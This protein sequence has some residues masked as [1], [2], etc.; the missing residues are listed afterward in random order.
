M[1][2]PTWPC[3]GTGKWEMWLD[4]L[5]WTHLQSDVGENYQVWSLESGLSRDLTSVC[6]KFL[7]L[8]L[9]VMRD[10]GCFFSFGL[11]SLNL[12]SQSLAML[13]SLAAEGW[14]C[15]IKVQESFPG[16]PASEFRPEWKVFSLVIHCLSSLSRSSCFAD[17]GIS[18]IVI[19]TS[20]NVWFVLLKCW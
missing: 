6:D 19:V 2:I 14:C 17:L 7:F 13:V 11:F 10:I 4:S 8:A 20:F 1:K 12:S 3:I 9:A 18:N 5:F 15:R 16:F